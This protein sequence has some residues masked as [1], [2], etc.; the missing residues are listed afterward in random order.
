MKEKEDMWCKWKTDWY[1]AV[2]WSEHEKP[3]PTFR[4]ILKKNCHGYWR[5]ICNEVLVII[6]KT[7]VQMK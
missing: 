2:L 7:S 6:A 5:K 3:D 4:A 1:R